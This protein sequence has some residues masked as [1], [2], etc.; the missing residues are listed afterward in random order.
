MNETL[1]LYL[2]TRIDT[3]IA[4]ATLGGIVGVAAL[5][6]WNIIRSTERGIPPRVPLWA[7][8]ALSFALAITLF[9]PSQKNLAIIIGGTYALEA[10]RSPEAKE[11]GGLVLDVVR[12]QLKEKK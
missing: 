10:A 5:A 3:F 2:F 12:A 4:I 8:V 11:L 6:I 9:V 1:L 7:G